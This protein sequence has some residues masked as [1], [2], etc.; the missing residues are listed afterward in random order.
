[1]HIHLVLIDP[2]RR[3]SMELDCRHGMVGFS[4][5]MERSNNLKGRCGFAIGLDGTASD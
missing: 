5:G 1:M 4:M 2:R 3:I